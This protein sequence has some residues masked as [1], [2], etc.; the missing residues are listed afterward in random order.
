VSASATP[1]GSERE[2]IVSRRA[3]SSSDA[4]AHRTPPAR[5]SRR[6]RGATVALGEDGAQQLLSRIAGRPGRPAA[7]GTGN[8]CRAISMRSLETGWRSA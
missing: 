2:P 7:R 3:R 5:A 6:R 4:R 8:G 1:G